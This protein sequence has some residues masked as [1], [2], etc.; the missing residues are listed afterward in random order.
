MGIQHFI[1]PGDAK[2]YLKTF[3]ET[4]S[5]DKAQEAVNQSILKRTG[6]LP[7]NKSVKGYLE[8]VANKT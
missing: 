7:K 1:G 6:K 2:L 3:N 4:G 8:V 5:Y